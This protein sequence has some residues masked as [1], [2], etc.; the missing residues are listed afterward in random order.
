VF[1]QEF[2]F[3]QRLLLQE[4]FLQEQRIFRSRRILLP[5]LRSPRGKT[6]GRFFHFIIFRP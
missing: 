2:F 3:G 1:I 6:V 4:F 5:Q